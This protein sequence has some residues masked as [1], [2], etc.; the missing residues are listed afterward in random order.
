MLLFQQRLQHI[1]PTIPDSNKEVT[2]SVLPS[3]SVWLLHKLGVTLHEN[4]VLL[5][6]LY[7]GFRVKPQHKFK[8]AEPS[9]GVNWVSTRHKSVM[10]STIWW[11]LLSTS[12]LHQ[13]LISL[14]VEHKP[15]QLTNM[16]PHV[17]TRALYYYYYSGAKWRILRYCPSVCLPSIPYSTLL[18]STPT[19]WIQMISLTHSA[20]CLHR[21][22]VIMCHYSFC[23]PSAR[24]PPTFL[25]HYLTLPVQ[26]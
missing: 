5:G 8:T 11:C 12:E 22:A 19:G 6:V 18:P 23:I 1:W 10:T 17:F 3:S 16:C 13:L 20:I 26:S 14:Y 4:A 21:H 25:C 9:K 7:L 15:L 24:K 2:C